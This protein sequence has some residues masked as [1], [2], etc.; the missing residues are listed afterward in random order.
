MQKPY[1]KKRG[2]CCILENVQKK[3]PELQDAAD[4]EREYRMIGGCPPVN[5]QPVSKTENSRVIDW[6]S[7]DAA[8][9]FFMK[10]GVVT[11]VWYRRLYWKSRL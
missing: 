10:K 3:A 1:C 9:Y 7:S 11:Y 5:L 2:E 4:E 8:R 6:T